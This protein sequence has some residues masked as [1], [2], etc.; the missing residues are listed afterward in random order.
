MT[1]IIFGLGFVNE[2]DLPTASAAT[3]AV[4]PAPSIF[5]LGVQLRLDLCCAAIVP[6]LN[7]SLEGGFGISCAWKCCGDV[8]ASNETSQ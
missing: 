8:R 2:F 3:T 5:F 1:S 7:G 6:S 4:V